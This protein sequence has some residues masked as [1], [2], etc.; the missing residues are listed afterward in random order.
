[1]LKTSVLT[2]AAGS[3]TMAEL[4][5][6]S[7]RFPI[8]RLAYSA[9]HPVINAFSAAFS[10][11][12]PASAEPHI[13]NI[14]LSTLLEHA[15]PDLYASSHGDIRGK[16]QPWTASDLSAFPPGA[17]PVSSQQVEPKA[18][19]DRTEASARPSRLQWSAL[20][21]EQESSL[22]AKFALVNG[23]MRD[24]IAFVTELPTD[25]TGNSIE[26]SQ[27]DSPNLARLAEMVSKRA[28]HGLPKYR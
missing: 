13:S 19:F 16:S 9:K 3:A 15:L 1:M 11:A 5:K 27:E 24:G 10:S 12:P 7:G 21:G 28:C 17:M 8:L 6:T 25:K 20:L 23:L 22:D 26:A 14:P 2:T 4:I 18:E